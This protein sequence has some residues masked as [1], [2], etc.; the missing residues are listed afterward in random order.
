[1]RLFTKPCLL[2]LT[3]IW[4]GSSFP[5]GAWGQSLVTVAGGGAQSPTPGTAGEGGPATLAPIAGL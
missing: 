4:I 1:M 2:L 3:V 5:S